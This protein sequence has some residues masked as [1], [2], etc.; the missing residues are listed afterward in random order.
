MAAEQQCGCQ[1]PRKV[2]EC[3][4]TNLLISVSLLAELKN[5]VLCQGKQKSKIP[6][7]GPVPHLQSEHL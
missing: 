4:N 2:E 5:D 6:E 1:K 7:T 3:A